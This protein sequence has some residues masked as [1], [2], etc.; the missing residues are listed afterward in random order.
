MKKLL[1][2]AILAAVAVVSGC[3]SPARSDS[4]TIQAA[5]AT[6]IRNLNSPLKDNIAVREVTGGRETNPAWVSN[7]SSSDLEAALET[8]LRSVNLLAPG[9]QAGKYQLIANLEKL[10]QP[11]VGVSMTVTASVGYILV[12]RASGKTVYQK[13]IS[14]PYTAAFGDAL[15]GPERLRLANEGAVRVNITRLIEELL[16][17]KLDGAVGTK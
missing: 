15:Y 14:L 12:E 7:V 5:D 9:K 3:A 16:S 13:S 1:I 2:A 6:R 17:L 11:F 4:M 10:D 8:S